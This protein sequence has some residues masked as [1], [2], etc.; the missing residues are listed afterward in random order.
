MMMM[1]MMMME[2][3]ITEAALCLSLVASSLDYIHSNLCPHLVV[4]RYTFQSSTVFPPS[5][6]FADL[7]LHFD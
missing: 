3:A 7:K 1:M 4:T 6:Y 2:A 5:L